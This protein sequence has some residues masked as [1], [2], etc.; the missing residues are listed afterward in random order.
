MIVG[1]RFI[2]TQGIFVGR[3]ARVDA[4]FPGNSYPK[5]F[6]AEEA[7]HTMCRASPMETFAWI[8]TKHDLLYA[9]RGISSEDIVLNIQL[10]T[11]VEV[12]RQQS[13]KSIR[14]FTRNCLRANSPSQYFTINDSNRSLEFGASRMN[15]R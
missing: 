13:P 6:A 9:E 12:F 7:G 14:V 11:E 2:E 10:G 8:S 1:R 4:A 3:Q 5:G 15:V